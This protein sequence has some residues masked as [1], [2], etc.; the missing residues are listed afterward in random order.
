MISS[1]CRKPRLLSNLHDFLVSVNAAGIIR[2]HECIFEIKH[3]EL[4]DPKLRIWKKPNI[5]N[6]CVIDNIDFKEK[7]FTYRNIYNATRNSSHATLLWQAGL[8]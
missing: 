8:D 5:W 7:V 3:I 4:A 2:K 6:I 1:L